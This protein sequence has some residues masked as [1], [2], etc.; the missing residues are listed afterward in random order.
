M[1]N[2]I[3]HDVQ[4]ALDRLEGFVR[5]IAEEVGVNL[6]EESATEETTD[7]QEQ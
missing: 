5:K 6:D 1:E 4:A 3:T 7:T 2:T